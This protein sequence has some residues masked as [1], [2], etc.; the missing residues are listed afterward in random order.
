MDVSM[1]GTRFKIKHVLSLALGVLLLSACTANFTTDLKSDGSGFFIQEYIMSVDELTTYGYTVG[2]NLCTE[3]MD[4]DLSDMPPGTT[5]RQ[6][7]NGEEIS[8]KF[9]TPFAT[10]DDLRVIYTDY[11]DSTV[12]DLRIDGN[13]VYYDITLDLGE[14]SES[15]GLVANWIVMLPGA[16]TDHNA[17]SQD[18]NSLTWDMASGGMLNTYAASSIGGISST[19][20]WI[21]GIT[22]SCLCIVALVAVVVL[23]IILAR[24]KKKQEISSVPKTP[25][26]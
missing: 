7:Q 2:E 17:D 15:I 16:V 8:C 1:Q 5:V 4:L 25:S 12:N 3:D 20:W 13:K 23:I 19:F 9:E 22:V 10:L 18:G 14:G 24:R 26:L 21:I 6:E 11:L